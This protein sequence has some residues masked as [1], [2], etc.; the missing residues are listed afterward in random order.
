MKHTP[1]SPLAYV[2]DGRHCLGHVLSRGPKGFEAFNTDDRSLGL[3]QSQ[4][5]A[6]N[7]LVEK[8]S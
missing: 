5:E 4:A 6:A 1:A 2:Y 8:S 3:F 7:A